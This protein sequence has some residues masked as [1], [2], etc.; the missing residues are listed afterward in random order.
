[1]LVFQ[2]HNTHTIRQILKSVMTVLS[3]AVGDHLGIHFSADY[4]F[5]VSF[6]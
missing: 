4:R 3:R 1:M 5:E 2:Y 6:L